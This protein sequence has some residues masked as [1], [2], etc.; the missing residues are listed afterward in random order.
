ML[1][2]WCFFPFFQATSKQ[3]VREYNETKQNREYQQLK[4]RFDYLHE[5]LSHIKQLILDYE[6]A[7][8]AASN[9]DN[10]IV[11]TT[12]ASTNI[13]MEDLDSRHY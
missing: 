2:R 3:I 7:I 6:K 1:I 5:K 11:S 13:N 8:S 9:V 4:K 12:T 10:S